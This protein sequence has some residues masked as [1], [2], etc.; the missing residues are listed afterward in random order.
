MTSPSTQIKFKNYYTKYF[1]R[2]NLYHHKYITS[3]NSHH[4]TILIDK[5]DL[6]ANEDLRKS[7]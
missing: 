3:I 4:E 2:E 7:S 1:K 5:K 6:N